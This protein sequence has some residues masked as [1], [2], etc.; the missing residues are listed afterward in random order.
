MYA[1]DDDGGGGLLYPHARSLV[2]ELKILTNWVVAQ[3]LLTV[4]PN[5]T[6]LCRQLP[7]SEE[8]LQTWS[9]HHR[10]AA[11]HSIMLPRTDE[12]RDEAGEN[13]FIMAREVWE[14]I[15][16]ITNSENRSESDLK[17]I[18]SL[19]LSDKNHPLQAVALRGYQKILESEEYTD[20]N[21]VIWCEDIAFLLETGSIRSC[22]KPSKEIH[23]PRCAEVACCNSYIHPIITRTEKMRYGI[24]PNIVTTR[25]PGESASRRMH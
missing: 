24:S 1:G 17:K 11:S 18:K 15:L 3:K 19:V 8:Q 25:K 12:Q 21:S 4:F 5:C 20:H 2:E 6:P 14:D 22:D 7:P 13:R 16:D 9:T 10:K 23:G